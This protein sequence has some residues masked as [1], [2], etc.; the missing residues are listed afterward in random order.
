MWQLTSF[1]IWWGLYWWHCKF[2]DIPHNLNFVY[3]GNG[4]ENVSLLIAK[5]D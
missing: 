3:Y 1:H 2:A 4:W 5:D